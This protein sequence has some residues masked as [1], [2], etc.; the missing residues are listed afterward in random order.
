MSGLPFFIRKPA[1]LWMNAKFGHGIDWHTDRALRIASQLPPEPGA[2][3][4]V[5]FLAERV[6]DKVA[7]AAVKQQLD[8]VPARVKAAIESSFLGVTARVA[9]LD[10]NER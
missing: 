9:R 2:L 5:K 4:S 1:D 6:G 8:S 3:V 10:I 7:L